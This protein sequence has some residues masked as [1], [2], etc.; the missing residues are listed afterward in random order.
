MS[1]DRDAADVEFIGPP[2]GWFGRAS[3]IPVNHPSIMGRSIYVTY[4]AEDLMRI[5]GIGECV[6]RKEP[7]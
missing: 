3:R 2:V 1:E 4:Y 7:L 5:D 6:A